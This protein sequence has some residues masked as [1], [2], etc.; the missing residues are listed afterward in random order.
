MNK[1]ISS[2]S[3]PNG[4]EGL[5]TEAEARGARPL[6]IVDVIAKAANTQP[7]RHRPCFYCAADAPS[8]A[9]KRNG[10]YTVACEAE[11]CWETP[12]VSAGSEKAAWTMWDSLGVERS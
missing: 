11:G 4:L 1:H 5:K 9:Y 3:F 7:V 6:T 10:I 2:P 8:A 12:A